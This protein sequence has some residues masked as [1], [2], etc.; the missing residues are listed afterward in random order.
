MSDPMQSPTSGVLAA[1]ATGVE[2]FITARGGDIDRIAGRSG[3]STGQ[4]ALPTD[5]LDLTAYCRLFEEAARETQD[6]NL[7]LWFGQQFQ[8]EM[9]GLVGYIA[10]LSATVEE[11]VRNLASHF[12][13]HQC[14][15]HTQLI[16]QKNGLLRLEYAIQDPTITQRRHDA[17]L[18]MGMF[19]NVLRHGMGE[20]WVPEA[21]LF[22]HQRPEQ[23][24]EHRDAFQADIRFGHATNALLFRK[25]G[26]ERPMPKANANMLEIMRASLIS[27]SCNHQSNGQA[28]PSPPLKEQI[29]SIIRAGL[30]ERCCTLSDIAQSMNMP[31]WTL[32]RRLAQVN[33]S[34]GALLEEVRYAE[35]CRHLSQ[36]G[37]DMGEIAMALG[38]TETS[39][40]SRAFRKWSGL[41]PR[42][43][44]EEHLIK[45]TRLNAP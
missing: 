31:A 9:L 29:A 15:T 12:G 2:E 20:D 23:T 28:T 16:E 13:Y 44:R 43:W 35:A 25:T 1:A 36:S 22:E 30:A 3:L 40:F 39:A 42:A 10:L 8:P 7:G 4:F 14:N 41:S 38:Y 17:E 34:F 24:H 27:L 5:R 33:L 21:V 37:S 6:G 26:L 32:Q 11:A 19:C 45:T 18:T